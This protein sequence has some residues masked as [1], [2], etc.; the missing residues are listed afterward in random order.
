MTTAILKADTKQATPIRNAVTDILKV[1]ENF[2]ALLNDETAALKRS[3]FATVDSL[4]EN[5][6]TI[7][8]TY[9]DM[10]TALG[11]R[12]EELQSLDMPMREKLIRA[13][14]TFTLILNDNMRVLE[15][16]K[17][18]TQRLS[19]RI[20][21][22]ARLSVVDSNQTSYGMKGNVQ[23]YKSSTLSTQLDRSL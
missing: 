7:A 11:A 21:D 6:R 9:H 2:S 1:L 18:S 16:V 8:R 17:R 20:L 15:L 22:I 13:R 14:T 12:A 3:D 10:V 5:K 23:S 4:Q 19:E